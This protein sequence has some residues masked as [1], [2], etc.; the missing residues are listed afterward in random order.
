M[1]LLQPYQTRH[2]QPCH[3][4]CNDA[5]SLA[6][7][8]LVARCDVDLSKVLMAFDMLTASYDSRSKRVTMSQVVPMTM[9]SKMSY[10]NKFVLRRM[11]SHDLDHL[12]GHTEADLSG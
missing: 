6:P 1:V 4:C 8:C 10:S 11:Y 12:A 5:I 2:P 9:I 3:T 7:N